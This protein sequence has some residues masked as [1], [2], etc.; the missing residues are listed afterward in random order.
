MSASLI[1]NLL[2]LSSGGESGFRVGLPGGPTLFCEKIVRRVPGK[3][4]VCQGVWDQQAV[5]A[6]L[7]I[8]S[9]AARYFERDKCGVE[10]LFKAGI[11]S[12]AILFAGLAGDGK[13][14]LIIFVAID[15]ARNAEDIWQELDSPQRLNL[16][17]ALVQT[18]AQHH[19]AGLLQTDLYLKNFLVQQVLNQEGLI[20][21]LDGD[22]IR[23]ISPWFKKRQKLHNLAMLF[24]KMDV[25]DD[26]WI[27]ELYAQYCLQSGIAH[28]H[29][30]EVEVWL[31]TQKIRHQVATGYADKKVF[32]NCT[33][34]KVTR[35]FKRFQ[36]V[37]SDFCVESQALASLDVF[38]ADSTL[39][40]KNGNTCTIAKAVVANRTV[41]VKRYNI[42]HFWHG[43]NRAFRVSRAAR[44]WANAYRLMISNI[45]TPKPLALD[46]ERVGC[47]RRRAYF[48]SE[49]IDAPDVMQFF[50][51]STNSQDKETVAHNLAA[52]FYKLYLLKLSHGDCKATN[53]KIVNFAPVLID[54]DGLQD[55]F[56]K[57]IGNW[58]FERKHIKDLK[59]LMRNWA[60][61]AEVTA[62]LKQAFLLE[63]TA[64][65]P[66]EDDGIL[67]R[68]GFA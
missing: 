37:A 44:S 8:G 55:H 50:A 51:Q 13:T 22:G 43:L 65:T 3:R 58:W 17:R 59:R 10:R 25:L 41:I 57:V 11:A 28:S 5:Y 45:A 23:S 62:L 21:T 47:F 31:L 7:F 36:A 52:L 67:F 40:I 20:Y 1:N 53:I 12:P 9:D 34:V 19:Q 61:D 32:R 68:A 14:H 39:N 35:S 18:V 4:L 26:V 54:L 29:A 56:G 42:K 46:E 66:S 15:S 30:D 33:D 6:K 64:Q 24:S 2:Q 38:L 63:Y 16:A 60:N 48:V 27:T 49:Y